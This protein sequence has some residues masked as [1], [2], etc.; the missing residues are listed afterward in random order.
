MPTRYRRPIPA[1]VPRPRELTTKDG[2]VVK[3]NRKKVKNLRIRVVAPDGHIEASVPLWMSDFEVEKFI[4]SKRDWIARKQA[5]LEDSPQARAEQ[6][7]EEEKR[8]WKETVSAFVPVFV[9]KWAPVLGVAPGKLD[10]RNMRS[11]WGSC[12]PT[13]GR[14]CISTRLA[15]YPPECLEYVVVH[16]LCHLREPGHTERFWALVESCLPDYRQAKALLKE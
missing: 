11:Q 3:L 16:E 2:F 10:Y 12:Q 15:L 6:A 14:I 5:A 7:S 4:H 1:S 13:T 9:E 8:E